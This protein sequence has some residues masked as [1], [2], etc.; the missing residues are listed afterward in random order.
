MFP[1]KFR[2][3]LFKLFKRFTGNFIKNCQSFQKKR[4]HNNPNSKINEFKTNMKKNIKATYESSCFKMDTIF[5]L[6]FDKKKYYDDL[7][8]KS[9]QEQT[10]STND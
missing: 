1:S 3:S 7:K 4:L 6:E 5:S 9:Q 10:N 2:T 8:E